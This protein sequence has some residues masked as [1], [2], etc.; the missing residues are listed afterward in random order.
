M[1]SP[2]LSTSAPPTRSPSASAL[3]ILA[4]AVL[5]KHGNPLFLQSYSAR[6]GGQADLKWQYAAHTSL[7]FFEERELP[8]AKT[9]DSYLG[10]LYA[11]EDYAV[12]GYQSNTRIKFVLILALADAVVRDID[13]K[14]IF[15]AIHNAYISHISNPSPPL[16][17]TIPPLSLHRYGVASS[18]RRWT[19][20]QEGLRR[21]TMARRH[22]RRISISKQ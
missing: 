13:V 14:T 15:R 6:R 21:K 9:I 5:G 16:R 4:I 12:Y 7:D 11:M 19:T 18:P 22:S 3:R 8:A 20:L 10:L 2:R 1:D 17:P